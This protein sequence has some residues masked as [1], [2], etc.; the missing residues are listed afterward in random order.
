MKKTN[1][2]ITGLVVLIATS[3]FAQLK[4]VPNGGNKKAWIG[5]RIGITDVTIQ[6][7]RPGVKGREGKIYGT[8]IVHTG[9]V[10][11]SSEYG[12]SKSAPWRAGANENTTIEFSTDVKIEGKDL[13]AGK[14]GF[15]IAYDP[16]ECIVIFSKNSTSWGNYFYNENEDVLRVKVK[17]T[18]LDKSVEWLKYEFTEQ[19]NTSTVIVMQWEKLSVPF[20]VEVDL[21]KTQIA[22]FRDELRGEKGFTWETWNQAAQFCLQ[23]DVNPEE[24][25]TWADMAM[26]QQ[27]NFQTYSTKAL[28]LDKLGKGK[29]ADSLMKEALPMGS[30]TD[31]H[32]YAKRLITL[33]KPANALEIFKL[34]AKKNPNQFTTHV[35]LARGYSAN[36]DFKNALAQ[37]KLALPLAPDPVNKSSVESMIKKLE[38]KQDIN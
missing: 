37:A 12:T 6:Y 36:A 13:P 23:N 38:N 17:P 4:S 8:P 11:K 16:K 29:Q 25:S 1:T 35:G 19:T 27:K 3:A 7:N 2:F 21:N 18:T 31:L 33:K 34:N 30:M 28:L 24:A 10:D 5:E 32:Q 15:F 26:L 20:K 9:F 22:S 14:Y